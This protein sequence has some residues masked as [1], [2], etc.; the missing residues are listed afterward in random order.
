MVQ[1]FW[2]RA[3]VPSSGVSQ[4]QV[5]MRRSLFWNIGKVAEWMMRSRSIGKNRCPF[6]QKQ[7]E[8]WQSGWMRRSRKPRIQLVFKTF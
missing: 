6:A 7:L 4:A 5:G 8:R 2:V 3:R 1:L